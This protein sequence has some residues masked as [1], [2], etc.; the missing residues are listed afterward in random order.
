MYHD[1]VSAK[2]QLAG[3][4]HRQNYHLTNCFVWLNQSVKAFSRFNILSRDG[5]DFL[6]VGHFLVISKFPFQIPRLEWSS[7]FFAVDQVHRSLSISNIVD[8]AQT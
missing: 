5:R 3:L 8:F 4:L 2:L 6:T 7:V 1:P